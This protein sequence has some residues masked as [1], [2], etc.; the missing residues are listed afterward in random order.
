[1]RLIV[2][3][4]SS[5]MAL[6]VSLFWVPAATFAQHY[7]QTNLITDATT[8]ATAAF[9]DPHLKNPWGLTR[10]ATS[11]WWISDNNGGVSTVY[12]GTP[13]SGTPSLV[14]TIPGPNASP[15]NF[16]SAPTGIVVNGTTEF[17]ITPGNT[18]T[19]AKFIFVT[20][21]G[22]ISAW[23]GG[24]AATLKV[25]NSANPSAANGAVYKGAAIGEYKGSFYL[26]V[27][28]FRSG[29]IEVYDTNF[30]QVTLFNDDDDQHG[31]FDDHFDNRFGDRF[32]DRFEDEEIP[33]GF[34]PFNVQNIGGSL[35]VT[36]AKQDKSR[37][38]NLA[39]PGLGF[40]DIYTSG[41]H[42][43]SRLQYG[44]WFNAPWGAVWAP[45]DFGAFSNNVM[46]GNF[47]SG[48]I[49]VFDGFSGKFLGLMQDSNSNTISIDGLWGLVFGNSAAGCPSTPPTAPAADVGLPKCSSS[50][51]YNSLFFTAGPNGEANGLFGTLTPVASELSSD[52]E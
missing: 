15:A 36:Y 23:A 8:T 12:S 33:R 51:P 32:A 9:V 40:V 18:A 22:T 5:C 44:P 37:H 27:A 31:H 28:N 45:R 20:E 21:D 16:V 30:N 2:R 43:E 41:G 48:Q 7:T 17:E 46:I 34:A 35:F 42:L 39:G 49:A 47:G 26:Y 1:M 52:F 3:L 6:V 50:G 10:S 19:A 38:D 14:V 13:A 11:P 29:H 24:S 4:A 25:D